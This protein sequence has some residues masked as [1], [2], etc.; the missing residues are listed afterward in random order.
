MIRVLLQPPVLTVDVC[1]AA[2]MVESPVVQEL[3]TDQIA[4]GARSLRIDLRDCTAIDST[5]S[6]L[7]LVLKRRLD[8]IG[9]GLTLVSPS[10]KVLDVLG[11]MGV[12]DLYAIEWADRAHGAWRELAASP[13]E[14][15]T[16]KR[17]VLEAHDELSRVPGPAAEAFEDVVHELRRTESVRPSVPHA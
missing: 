3:A 2:S 16:L 10:R 17:V 8:A 13:P 1:G 15:E 7:L 5:F 6:G 14:V 4:L 12:D 9:G 11:Y